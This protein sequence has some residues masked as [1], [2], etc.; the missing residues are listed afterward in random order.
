MLSDEIRN[1][2]KSCGMSQ[3]ELA[4]ASRVSEA[5]IS[6]FVQGAELRSGTL[7]RLALVLG[8]LILRRPQLLDL[9]DL[10]YSI[11]GEEPPRRKPE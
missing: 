8:V 9:A 6:R 7:D 4:E 1:Y 11:C 5:Q 2:V 10:L 3:K